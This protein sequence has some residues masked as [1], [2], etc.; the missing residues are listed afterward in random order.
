N[1]GNAGVRA[2]HGRWPWGTASHRTKVSGPC[3]PETLNCPGRAGSA[4]DLTPDELLDVG[5]GLVVE[6][7][8]R[9][10][11]HE[12]RRRREDRAADAPVLGDLRGTQGVDDDTGG[13]R[14]VPDLQ[15]VL[16]VQ[17]DVT[18]G[19][20]LEADVGPLAVVEPGDVVGRADVDVALTEL[21]VADL[22]G[23][24][25]RLGDLLGLQAV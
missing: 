11:L 15:L 25:L 14:G 21:P 1:P 10:G 6:V 16:E 8:H 5:V 12:V 3:D 22:R 19:T 18:E 2:G 7:L 4:L 23:D 17:R 13:V 20:A 9:R 24:G